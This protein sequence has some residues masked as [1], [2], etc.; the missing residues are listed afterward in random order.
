MTDNPLTE[1]EPKA[2]IRPTI[3]FRVTPEEYEIINNAAIADNRKIGTFVRV[4]ALRAIA[5]NTP[6]TGQGEVM[7]SEQTQA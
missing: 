1:T 7:V 3:Q 6:K 5:Q 4:I 2:D